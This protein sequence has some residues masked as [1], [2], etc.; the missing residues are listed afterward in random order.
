MGDVLDW[1]NATWELSNVEKI[2]MDTKDFC[3]D[4]P[5]KNYYMLPERRSL[6]SG[7]SVCH[8]MGKFLNIIQLFID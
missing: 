6:E 7:F 8:K 1:N 2:T 4:L 3:K 5:E